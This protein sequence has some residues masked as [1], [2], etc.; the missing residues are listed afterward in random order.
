MDIAGLSI[1]MHQSTLQNQVEISLMKMTMDNS[2]II[3]E[4]MTEMI[5]NMAIDTNVGANL[6]VSV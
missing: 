6:D 4:N 3:N 1:A 5:D 2:N